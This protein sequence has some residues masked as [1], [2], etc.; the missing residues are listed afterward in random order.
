MTTKNPTK[1]RGLPYPQSDR[2][3]SSSA[4]EGPEA[5]GDHDVL[6]GIGRVHRRD[7][8]RPPGRP[9]GGRRGRRRPPGG[10][11]G[12][13]RER[14]GGWWAGHRRT[15]TTVV[16]WPRRR[17][18][19]RRKASRVAP[20]D[21]LAGGGCAAAATPRPA[22]DV[23]RIGT[24]RCWPAPASTTTTLRRRSPGVGRCGAAA[25]VWASTRLVCRELVG[26]S[27]WL[28]RQPS[29]SSS[30]GRLGR[31]GVF[32]RFGFVPPFW[33]FGLKSAQ[34]FCGGLGGFDHR[35]CAY[36]RLYRDRNV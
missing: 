10:R 26:F 18:R 27:L 33:C 16:G 1:P 32:C 23:R 28:G 22:A 12:G 5:D 21:V 11:G 25:R 36:R 7:G 8:R 31:R 17:R 29:S 35:R 6:L 14:R 13:P 30:E 3:S 34:V 19:R 9:R 4:P 15:T 24:G 2:T 20:D